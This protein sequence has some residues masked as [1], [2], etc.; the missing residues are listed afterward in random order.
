MSISI[1]CIIGAFALRAPSF[2]E[3]DQLSGVVSNVSLKS[4]GVGAHVEIETFGRKSG[5][6]LFNL[7]Q[8]AKSANREVRSFEGGENVEIWFS[9]SQRLRLGDY[10]VW[11]LDNDGRTIV[12]Y[13]DL[14]QANKFYFNTLMS[15]GVFLLILSIVLYRRKSG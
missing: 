13:D 10:D 11:Q 12:S 7:A 15:L 9:S 3:L 14:L 8:L 6:Y 4:N 5:S 2:S 1:V